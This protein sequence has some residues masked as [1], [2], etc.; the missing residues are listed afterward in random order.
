M[1]STVQRVNITLPIRTLQQIDRVAS[2]GNRSHLI[3]EAIN[4]YMQERRRIGVQ[5]LLRDGALARAKQDRELANVFDLDDVW[6]D[7]RQ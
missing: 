4:F 6:G 5:K 2:P 1:K 7:H 3:D